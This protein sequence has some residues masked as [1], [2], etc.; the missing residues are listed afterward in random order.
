[1]YSVQYSSFLSVIVW[2]SCPASGHDGNVDSGQV[3]GR[4]IELDENILHF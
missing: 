4:E 3:P 2:L 1:M